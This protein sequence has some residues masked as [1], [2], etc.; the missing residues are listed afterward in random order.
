MNFYTVLCTLPFIIIAILGVGFLIM[1]HE[2]G[3]YLFAKLFN[4][5]TPSFSIG[6]GPRLIEKKIGDTVFALSAIPLGGYV[7]MAGSAEVGQGEQLHADTTDERS[8]ASKPYWQK[9]LII[10]GG[11]LFNMIFAYSALGFLFYQGAPCLG[12]WCKNQ[13]PIIAS[14]REKTPAQT[15]GLQP[16]DKFISVNSKPVTSIADVSNAIKETSDK[17]AKLVINRAGT[18]HTLTATV[19]ITKAGPRLNGIFWHTPALPFTQAFAKAWQ[20][21]WNMTGEIFQALKGVTKSTDGLGGPLALISQVTECAGM[22]FKIFLFML[23]FISV[24]LA[25]FNVLPLPIFDGGQALFFTIEALAGRPLPDE[26][27]YKIHYASWILV[28]GLILYL[29]Y[30]DILKL[31]GF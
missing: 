10:A 5:H 19:D 12:S 3:H 16:Q 22:G 2:L 18:E 17:Q 26:T 8:L 4:V 31:L 25:V 14:V 11:I 30:R 29:T 27:R 28:M 24:N 21:T 13:P 7:E 20:A 6:F 23:A 1:F 9:M 15:A